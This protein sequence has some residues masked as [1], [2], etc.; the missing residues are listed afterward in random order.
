MV[1]PTAVTLKQRDGST[2]CKVHNSVSGSYSQ[3]D[4]GDVNRETDTKMKG[5]D[6]I[7]HLE[8][9]WEIDIEVNVC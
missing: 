2:E 6:T 7:I 1:Q 3:G 5:K 4:P 8:N 9:S